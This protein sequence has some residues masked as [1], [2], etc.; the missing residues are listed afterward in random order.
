MHIRERN[1]EVSREPAR[2][3][4]IIAPA[5]ARITTPAVGAVAQLFASPLGAYGR[6]QTNEIAN[7]A[8]GTGTGARSGEPCIESDRRV[9]DGKVIGVCTMAYRGRNDD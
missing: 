5:A 6:G 8:V 9:F 1:Q 7:T 3:N 2:A 4:S